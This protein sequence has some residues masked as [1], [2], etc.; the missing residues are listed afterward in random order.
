M[1]RLIPS[2]LLPLVSAALPVMTLGAQP[3]GALTYHVQFDRTMDSSMSLGEL[4][5]DTVAR[6]LYGVGTKVIDIDRGIVVGS[7]SSE[8]GH[9]YAFADALGRAITRRG[10]IFDLRTR[11]VLRAGRDRS[12][13]AVSYDA[14]TQ[15]A[16]MNFDSLVVLDVQTAQPVGAVWV[17]ASKYVVSDHQGHFLVGLASD[18]LSVVDAKRLT[19][20]Q[21]WSLS[22]CHHLAS[23]TLDVAQRRLFA[24]CE[25]SQ[26]VVV[27]YRTGKI[28][29]SVLVAKADQLA[30]DAGTGLLFVPTN[31]DTLAIVM[32]SGHRKYSVASKLVAGPIVSAVAVDP[33][34]HIVYVEHFGERVSD[35][36]YGIALVALTQEGTPGGTKVHPAPRR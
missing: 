1:L 5:I 9:G 3:E 4:A 6:T 26:L 35:E 25:N 20:T 21:R 16:A 23:M 11:A 14:S 32:Q 15:R 8:L 30:F 33:K 24:S 7:I 2:T 34:T 12:A 19:I 18:S 28:V 27:D 22:P 17:G 31:H 29:T 10:A 36:S 13:S